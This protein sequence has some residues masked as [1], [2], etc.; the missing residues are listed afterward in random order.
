MASINGD[1]FHS[2]S[3][4]NLGEL[5]K[6]RLLILESRKPE[7]MSFGWSG[8][9]QGNPKMY[10]FASIAN[11]QP[12]AMQTKIRAMIRY[13]FVREGNTCPLVWTQMGSL[14]NDLY[15][16]GNYGAAKNVYELTLAI[17]LALYAF[18]NS[19][20]QFSI[21]P[22][23]GEMP[24]KFLF[25]ILGHRASI[26]LREFE[27]L[28]DGTTARVGGNTSYWQ[29]DIV[30]SG[31]FKEEQGRLFYTGKYPEFVQE[32]K[33]FNP[34]PLLT[35]DDWRD[36]R[37]NPIIGI[38]P[39]KNSIQTIFEELAREQSLEDQLTDGILT[40]P[41]VD[42]VAEQ[43][44]IQIPEL[45]IL[46]TDSRFS[47]SIRRVRNA[48]WAIRIKKKYNYLCAVP[49][50]DVTGLVFVEAAHIKPDSASES[51]V[52]HR[53]HILNGLC[54]CKNCHVAFDK[55]YFSLTD[56]HMIVTSSKFDAIPNQ[57]LKTVILSSANTIIKNRTDNRFPLAEFIQ[58]HRTNIFKA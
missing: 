22:A 53:D 39:F 35:D 1:W 54:F 26:S 48:T 49:N 51:S 18:N 2:R 11:I 13:G 12:S 41:L 38:S 23:K 27:V 40:E 17:S 24:L 8:S 16:V 15:T 57:N 21:N 25:N 45:D 34:N 29:S 9:R 50:C 7:Y 47:Q 42:I 36:I 10:Q 28:V 56:D 5:L 58:Y 37:E 43:E 44:E 31:L 33:N 4:S 19:S 14:W 6:V 30:N 55:G 52:P 46:S 32:I 20:D 3:S